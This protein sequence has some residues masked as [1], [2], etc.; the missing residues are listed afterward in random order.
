MERRHSTCYLW[1]CPF[2][3]FNNNREGIN[4]CHAVSIARIQN[5]HR[6]THHARERI[7]RKDPV[8]YREPRWG[9]RRAE[10][11]VL[12]FGARE[13]HRFQSPPR[14]LLLQKLSHACPHSC[15]AAAGP[16]S[17]RGSR[18]N[19]RTRT[20]MRGIRLYPHRVPLPL[21]L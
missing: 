17:A 7:T 10:A 20:S 19:A 1:A 8:A 2:L 9:W 21:E 4:L 16:D 6:P 15:S 3:F 14:H 13:R 18:V 11:A 5:S 12:A